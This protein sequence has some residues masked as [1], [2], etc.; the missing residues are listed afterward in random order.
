MSISFLSFAE[1]R[2]PWMELKS[3]PATKP[4]L[5]HA[6]L[7]KSEREAQHLFSATRTQDALSKWIQTQFKDNLQDIDGNH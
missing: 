4:N 7:S 1:C 6:E 2:T 3:A 5:G